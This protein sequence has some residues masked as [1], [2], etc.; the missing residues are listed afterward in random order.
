MEESSVREDVEKQQL[1]Q[2]FPKFYEGNN[3]S[4]H[5]QSSF[6]ASNQGS[7]QRQG[8]IKTSEKKEFERSKNATSSQ[9]EA[10]LG[11]DFRYE[12]RSKQSSKGESNRQY[13]VR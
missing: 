13:P 7:S 9:L 4:K 2:T 5:F 11:E 10:S 12:Q 3:Y 8:N 1:E 6:K